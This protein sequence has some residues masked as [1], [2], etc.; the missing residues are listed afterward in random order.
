MKKKAILGIE[1]RAHIWG[2]FAK[3]TCINDFRMAQKSGHFAGFSGEDCGE[4]EPDTGVFW[5]RGRGSMSR[6]GLNT[7]DTYNPI[8]TLFPFALPTFGH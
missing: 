1:I 8:R 5:R 3:Y 4:S 7:G 6:T 2:I